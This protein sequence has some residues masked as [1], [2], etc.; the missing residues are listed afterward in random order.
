MRAA[1]W[2]LLALVCCVVAHEQCG[3]DHV[4]E[5]YLSIGNNREIHNQFRAAVAEEMRTR[6]LFPRATTL[7]KIPVVWHVLYD[8]AIPETYLSKAQIDREMGYLND[9][10]SA[11]NRYYTTADYFSSRVASASDLNI[12]FYLAARDPNNNAF[13]GIHYIQSSLAGS[14]CPIGS[15]D[16]FY[17]SKGG[18]K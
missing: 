16:M 7:L 3:H 2:V 1:V 10:Y 11:K 12:Q 9:W 5:Q 15:T 14:G 17:T 4:M 13:S 6:G 18:C 8:P